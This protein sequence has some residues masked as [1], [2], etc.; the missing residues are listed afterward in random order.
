MAA[1]DVI[2]HDL[3]PTR[4][5]RQVLVDGVYDALV[6]FLMSGTLLPGDPVG[7]DSLSR[8]LEVSPTPIR[9]A[10]ARI[11]ATGLVV[12]EP[13]RGYRVAPHMSPK[14]LKEI[15]EARLLLEPYNAAAAAACAHRS[16]ELLGELSGAL[17]Q[18]REAPTGPTYREFREFLWADAHFHQII[19]AHAGN[20]FLAEALA[21]LGAHLHRFRLFGG[22]GVTDAPL[23][24]REHEAVFAAIEQGASDRARKAM[25]RHLQ[26]VLDRA[27]REQQRS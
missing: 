24:V 11:E 7:I 18:M 4:Q 16:E 2:G 1:T 27:M 15:M 26:G 5:K 12:R 17:A 21:R 19:A 22:A 6:T 14:D 23:T 20:D 9:E 13:L 10:L 25:K 3:R 8:S